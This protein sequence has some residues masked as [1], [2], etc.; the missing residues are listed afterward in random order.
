MA[1]E[2]IA[3]GE[4]AESL[5]TVEAVGAATGDEAVDAAVAAGDAEGAVLADDA[6]A[7][8]PASSRAEADSRT[9]FFKVFSDDEWLGKTIRYFFRRIYKLEW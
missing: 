8:H 4:E 7:A 1:D 3:A 2:V 6:G 9:I 5:A